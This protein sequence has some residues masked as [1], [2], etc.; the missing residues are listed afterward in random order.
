ML[1]KRIPIALF[2]LLLVFLFVLGG[3]SVGEESSESRTLCEEFLDYV[4]EDD[5]DAAYAMCKNITSEAEFNTFWQNLHNVFKD[6]ESYELKQTRWDKNTDN[7]VTSTTVTFEATTDDGKMC[8]VYLVTVPEVEG[9]AGIHFTDVTEFVE[10]AKAFEPVNVILKV[11]SL[12]A[13]GFIVWMFVDCMRRTIKRKVLWAIIICVGVAFSVTFGH[14]N[15]SFDWWLGTPIASSGITANLSNLSITF[16]LALPL[17]AI[18]YFFARKKL[19]LKEIA[20]NISEEV[21]QHTPE[22]DSNSESTVEINTEENS[23]TVDE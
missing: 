14:Q 1:T 3:C 4:I 16:T 6:S 23:N 19:T 13:F 9:I 5:R 20:Q 7:G 22:A 8:M 21:S 17:G 18:I 11:V 12:A 2:C 15:I 10:N